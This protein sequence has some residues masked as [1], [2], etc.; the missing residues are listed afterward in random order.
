MS[1]TTGNGQVG[2]RICLPSNHSRS[3]PPYARGAMS[4]VGSAFSNRPATNRG[5][6]RM[7]ASVTPDG[8]PPKARK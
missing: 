5:D 3:T 8:T 4:D 2:T 7:R 1:G 6:A